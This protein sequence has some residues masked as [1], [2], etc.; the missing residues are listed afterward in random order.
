MC[1]L[2]MRCPVRGASPSV[3]FCGDFRVLMATLL[4][5]CLRAMPL[6]VVPT[7]TVMRVARCVPGSLRGHGHS[8]FHALA[9]IGGETGSRCWSEYHFLTRYQQLRNL[10]SERN[11]EVSEHIPNGLA[12]VQISPAGLLLLY[13]LCLIVVF[14]SRVIPCVESWFGGAMGSRAGP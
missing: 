7:R 1:I 2:F 8:P 6:M 5:A 9:E 11:N 4:L 14:D 13:H 12:P 3:P 10:G